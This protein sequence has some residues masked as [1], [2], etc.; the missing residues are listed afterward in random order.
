MKENLGTFPSAYQNLENFLIFYFYLQFYSLFFFLIL[1]WARLTRFYANGKNNW[2][3]ELIDQIL[4]G[5]KYKINDLNK[6]VIEKVTF[7]SLNKKYKFLILFQTLK[8][9]F[10]IKMHLFA[11]KVFFSYCSFFKKGNEFMKNS[12]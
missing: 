4:Y 8:K 10:S 5:S 7:L 3:N 11:Y 12:P 9:Y 6:Y 2:F 1:V